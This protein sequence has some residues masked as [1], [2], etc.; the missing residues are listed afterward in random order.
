VPVTVGEV[1]RTTGSD[2]MAVVNVEAYTVTSEGKSPMQ[3]YQVTA[4]L[5]AVSTASYPGHASW[6]TPIV[7]ERASANGPTTIVMVSGVIVRY[8]LAVHAMDKD[9]KNAVNV[10]VVVHDAS[11]STVQAQSD[12][13]GVATFQPIGWIKNADGTTDNS[14]TPYQVT[15]D[16]GGHAAQAS[17]NL[18]GNT[19]LDLKVDLGKQFDYG[20]AII[21]GAV[22]AIMFGATLWVV[23]RKP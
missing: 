10:T 3:S 15:A 6:Q 13:N 20:P 21:I 7:T 23:R 11:G 12:A 2:G 9:G 1:H 8:D 4:N 22:A 14:M 19:N 16:I 18:T 5:T 17:T